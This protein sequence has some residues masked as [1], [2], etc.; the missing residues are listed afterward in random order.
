[1]SRDFQKPFFY[2][3][4]VTGDTVGEP[5]GIGQSGINGFTFHNVWNKPAG[6]LAG[7]LILE[8]S[9][10]PNLEVSIAI[11]DPTERIT[12][13]DNDS[14]FNFTSEVPSLVNPTSGFSQ[15]I[16]II[17]NT[18]FWWIRMRLVAVGGAGTFSSFPGSHGAG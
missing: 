8:G 18:R 11:P 15:Q 1:M 9:N 10:D 16:V 7:T 13:I 2:M 14:W 5:I 3:N 17:N 6:T 12:A 4:L